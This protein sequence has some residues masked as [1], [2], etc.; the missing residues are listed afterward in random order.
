MK[1]PL[2]ALLLCLAMA[3]PLAAA[4]SKDEHSAHHPEGQA[5]PAIGVNSQPQGAASDAPQG[6]S[7]VEQGMKRLQELMAQIEQSRDPVERETLLPEHMIAMLEQIKL[8]R[9]QTEGKTMAMVM[10]G[11]GGQGMTSGDKKKSAMKP[12]NKDK[13]GGMICGE[14]I[15]D[16]RMGGGMMG[17]HKMMGKQLGMVEQLLEQAIEHAHMRE[18]AE[19]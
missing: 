8:M 1:A 15:G 14:M 2:L 4:Q 3:L 7:A 6:P 12:G 19:H 5:A 13:R 9:S 16:G 18:A 11:G 10:M 17:K